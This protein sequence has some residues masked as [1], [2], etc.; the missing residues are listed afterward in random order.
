MKSIWARANVL[1]SLHTNMALKNQ[2]VA[3]ET[4]FIKCNRDLELVHAT[5]TTIAE[6]GYMYRPR[7][8]DYDLYF[9]E[10]PIHSI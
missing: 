5:L 1:C 3:L 10:L 4:T 7:Y 6:N 8:L 9:V 2:S